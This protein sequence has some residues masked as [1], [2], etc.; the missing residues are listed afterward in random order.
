MRAAGRARRPTADSACGA[1]RLETETISL[2]TLKFEL[3][4]IAIQCC[5]LFVV[6]VRPAGGMA[7]PCLPALRPAHLSCISS[8]AFMRATLLALCSPCAAF[9][10]V[11]D[12]IIADSTA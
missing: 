6:E 7:D 10:T 5:K 11:I 4:S 9:M 3:T 2:L 8:A 12:K 1:L